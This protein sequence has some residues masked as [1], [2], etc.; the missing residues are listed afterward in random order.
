[1][2]DADVAR[3]ASIG[4]VSIADVDG[5]VVDTSCG[6]GHTLRRYQQH[7]PGRALFGVDLS[8]RMVAISKET[9][10]DAATVVVGDMRRPVH[11]DAIAP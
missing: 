4:A 3:S 2:R 8:P 5:P 9:L 11:Q 10:G 6:S 7:D 1:M